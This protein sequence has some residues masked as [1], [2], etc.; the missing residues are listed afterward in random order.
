MP[1][2]R[3]LITPFSTGVQQNLRPFLILEDAWTLLQNVYVFRGRIR[4]RLG[5][6][7][8]GYGWPATYPWLAPYYSRVRVQLAQSTDGSGDAA[9][10][11]PGTIFN[12]GS[13]FSIGNVIYTV[14]GLGTPF[15]MTQYQTP[16]APAAPTTL[17]TFNT[18]T[19]AFVFTGAPANSHIYFYPGEPIMGLTVYDQA[20]TTINNQPSWAFD[21]Q[22]AY[23]FA[24][25]T[26]TGM[27]SPLWHDPSGHKAN[28]FWADNW[29]GIELVAGVLTNYQLMFVTNYQVAQP[30]G[31]TVPLTD[32]P[33]YV[34]NG[35]AWTAYYAYFLPDPAD[36]PE[37]GSFVASCRIII[38]FKDRLLLLN[39]IECDNANTGNNGHNTQYT[40][41][42]RYSW[43][44]NPLA[45]NAWYE[46]NTSDFAGNFAAGAG[47]IDASTDEQI[48]SAEFIKD[49]L[50]VFF[51]RSTW[52]IIYTGSEVLPFRWQ[53]IN[54]ELGSQSLLSS[55]PFDRQILT[56][57][58]VGVH[59]CNGANVQRIDEKI[60]DIIFTVRTP[61]QGIYRLSGIRDYY[62]ELAYWTFPS[63]RIPPSYSDG[64]KTLFPD[65]LLVYNYQNGSW[66][67]F[68][69]CITTFGEL[70]QQNGINW[71]ST[72]T[73]TETT[74][75]W[76][77]GTIQANVR[78]T[79]AG[80]Q[81]G[82]I[83]IPDSGI[84]RNA[85][86]MQ[87][88]NVVVVGTTATLTILNHTLNPG[89]DYIL[90]E[91]LQGTNVAPFNNNIFLVESAPT[92]NTITITSLL[93]LAVTYNGGGSATRVSNLRLMSKQW[94]P[95][96][97]QDT[98]LFLQRIDFQVMT[99]T[100]GQITV[101]YFP[102]Y[103]Q[104][105]ML[106]EG[107]GEGSILGT[108]VL[109]TSPYPLYP[110]EEEQ[111]FVWHPVYFQTVGE[112]IQ[113]SMY[114]SDEQMT[115][116][117]NILGPFELDGMTLYTQRSGRAQ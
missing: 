83:F 54:T 98:N 21:T 39:T 49:R 66:A 13:A 27:P 106:E 55:V 15:N 68:D 2:D 76:G 44:G 114:M 84:N 8:S 75:T 9:N 94:N 42:C 18:T 103:S 5:G 81:Q 24:G 105:S 110:L 91:N 62:N 43:N 58:N 67:G 113:I 34:Y 73:W 70:E 87:V 25:G 64:S 3:F 85:P 117:D 57:G 35:A 63:T 79:A 90:L 45:V 38:Q 108:G 112:A 78:V 16:L 46:P 40:N 47:Y 95:Y 7:L 72:L 12:V 88:S 23:Q 92:A 100:G 29:E 32:D 93:F 50:I 65:S 115:N 60:P 56:M 11:V 109:E 74:N 104:L 14:A 82:Y 59:A 48:V 30:N 31:V 107:I 116:V 17:A 26:W 86:V 4:K 36:D 28:F 53:K 51:E 97:S 102:S 33:I 37:T 41:R 111:D 52:E 69:D 89:Y 1:F 22:F 80:N 6:R 71:S 101:D 20:A 19:G 99:T 61:N 77:D 10:T 96:I